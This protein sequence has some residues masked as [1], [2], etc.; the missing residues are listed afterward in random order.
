MEAAVESGLRTLKEATVKGG[1]SLRLGRWGLSQSRAEKGESGVIGGSGA[2][3][4][5]EK[6][7]LALDE[8]YHESTESWTDLFRSLRRR[9]VR[10][11]GMAIADGVPG[12]EKALRDVFPRTRRQRCRVHK[13]RNI[14]GK[15]PLKA[16]EEVHQKFLAMY[17]ARSR[18]EA[19]R[20][21]AELVGEYRSVYPNAVC[22]IDGGGRPALHL[23]RHPQEPLEEHEVYECHRIGLLIGEVQNRCNPQDPPARLGDLSGAQAPDIARAAV[24]PA[25]GVQIRCSDHRSV[26][27]E[28]AHT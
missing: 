7:L 20:L 11:I 17:H 16:Y 27:T 5:G 22:L 24:S 3:R 12:V 4:R 19:L 1:I 26:Q 14:P 13:I 15:V 6:E 25:A 2:N 23:L 8:G 28:I 10:W 18:E 21:R 9:G